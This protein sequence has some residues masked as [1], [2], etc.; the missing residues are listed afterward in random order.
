MQQKHP[1]PK[2]ADNDVLLSGEKPYIHP[3]I[4]ESINEEIVKR[5]ALKTKGRSGPS[6]LDADGW[7]KIL[8]S[9]NY[10]TVNTD[11]RK[12]LTEVIKSICTKKIEINTETIT[13]SLEAF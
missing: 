13:T 11:L 5:A 2:A 4:Y 12:A 7:R 1:A 9:N 3:V 8:A 6:G 10:G